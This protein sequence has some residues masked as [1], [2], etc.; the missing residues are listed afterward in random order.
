MS[1]ARVTGL[2]IYPV[3]S[4]RGISLKEMQLGPTGPVHDRQWM[5]VDEKN[6]F[7]TLRTHSKLAEI[8]TSLQGPFLHL[9]LGSNKVQIQINQDDEKVETVT[10][11]G[12]S[13]SAGVATKD[14]NEAL[15]DFLVQSVKLVRYQ[16]Q[17]F[18]DITKA[19]TSVVK[20][21]M[22]ADGH[23]V[24][25]ANENSLK[26]LNFKLT[27]QNSSASRMERF[28][29]NIIIDGLEAFAEDR[30]HEVKIGETILTQPKLCA[31]CPIV[32]QDEETGTVISKETL[33]TLADYRKVGSGH[34][35]MFGLNLTPSKLGLIR[36]N[37]LVQ[38]LN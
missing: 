31:R 12:D 3:K 29:A 30:I 13:F 37:D 33:K 25:L 27:S 18:R 19:A 7:M 1:E 8:K 21:T 4:C 5:I 17:S 28:R 35:V 20:E 2:W 26:D 22:F 36:L 6:Q 15:S 38:I 16:K 11:W 34:G 9:Y 10:V 14:I 32:T 23:P 24:L